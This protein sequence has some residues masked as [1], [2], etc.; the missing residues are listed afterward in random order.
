M[1]E[2]YYPLHI[3]LQ[4]VDEFGADSGDAVNT[5]NE[6]L[7]HI[8]VGDF[9]KNPRYQGE[10]EDA[11]F[12]GEFVVQEREFCETKIDAYSRGRQLTIFI[13]ERI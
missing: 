8:Q 3:F 5:K 2:D 1:S 7:I 4:R 11:H 13:R 12:A 10:D 9:L 6:A